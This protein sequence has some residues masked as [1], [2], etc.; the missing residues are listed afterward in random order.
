[1]LGFLYFC[2]FIGDFS[3]EKKCIKCGS[4]HILMPARVTGYLT[5]DYR[6]SFNKGKQK[7]KE[8]REKH[9]LFMNGLSHGNC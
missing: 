9:S 5:G 6:I 7:E 4:D 3:I 2:G 8:D 1:M